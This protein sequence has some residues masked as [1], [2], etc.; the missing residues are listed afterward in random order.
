MDARIAPW[1]RRRRRR[2]PVKIRRPEGEPGDQQ[3]DVG[4]RPEPVIDALEHGIARDQFLVVARGRGG[5]VT[6]N[7]VGAHARLSSGGM[8]SS[9]FGPKRM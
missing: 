4:E 5:V 3:I 1:V 8:G 7:R 9:F 6:A 2:E